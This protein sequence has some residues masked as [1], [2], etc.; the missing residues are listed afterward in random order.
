MSFNVL[1]IPEDFTKDQHILKPVVEKI[2]MEIGKPNATVEVCLDPNLGGIGQAL[3]LERL[4]DDVVVQYPMVDLFVLLVDQDGLVGRQN[5]IKQI[6][7]YFEMELTPRKK[8]FVAELA[9]QEVEA[10]I[11]AGQDLPAD[12][13]WKD[14][15]NDPDV[16]NTYFAKL[17]ALKNTSRFPYEGRKTLMAE[18]IKNWS[19]IK[20]RCPE[21]IGNLIAKLS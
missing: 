5:S 20:S 3:K 15:R 14:I 13:K 10:F 2:L 19:R 6:E 12:W 8:Q 9:R 16:K 17:V 4:R 18:S 1:V 7:E 11:L 21:D